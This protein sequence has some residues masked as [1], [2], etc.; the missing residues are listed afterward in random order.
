MQGAV[1]MDRF[2]IY[3][4]GNGIMDLQLQVSDEVLAQLGLE[5][6]SF[7]LVGVKEQQSLLEFFHGEKVKQSS[8]GSAANTIIAASQLGA[9]AAY[10]CMLGGDNYGEAYRT[11]FKKLGIVLEGG[12]HRELMSGTCVI[13]ITP[14]AERTMNTHLGASALFSEKD[15]SEVCIKA[16]EWLYVEGYLFSS[17]AGQAAALHSAELAKK[18]GVKIAVSFADSFIV[19]NFRSP[20]EAVLRHADLIFANANE[21]RAY[22]GEDSEDRV[23]GELKKKF[24]NGI[25]TLR[26]RGARV[27]LG[28]EE[29]HV[30]SYSVKAVDETGAGDMFAG[31][32]LYG[33]THGYSPQ[34][35]AKLACFLASRVVTQVGPRLSGNLRELEG[36]GE[37]LR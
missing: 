34:A 10:S 16:C 12:I 2:N 6:G 29:F 23:F 33:I 1:G 24:P 37:V 7:R 19:E 35:S 26:E 30:P 32:F 36:I 17:P 18:Q 21:A 31:G 27:F 15:V 13:L 11:E 8:G 14:D 28:G 25:M 3:G 5:K 20:L 4:I 9:K 22:V